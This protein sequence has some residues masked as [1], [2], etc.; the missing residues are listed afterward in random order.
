MNSNIGRILIADDDEAVRIYMQSFLK[1]DRYRLFFARDGDEAIATAEKERPD[2]IL[3]DVDMPGASGVQVC[4][5]IKSNP[6]LRMIPVVLVTSMS[7]L[8]SRVE[9]L[10]AGADDFFSK[11]FEPT[12]LL[13]RIRSLLT[14]KHYTDQLEHAEKVIASLALCV[15][16]KDT[17]TGGHCE[18]LSQYAVNLGRQMGLADRELRALRLG[19]ILHDLGKIAVPDAV[20]LKP[21]P[22]T[23]EEWKIMRNHP[24]RGI[25]LCLPLQSLE[26]V[27]PAIKHH[28]ERWNGSGYPDHLKGEDIPFTARIMAV[29]DVYDALR[30]RRSYKPALSKEDSL[31]ILHKEVEYGFWDP[32]IVEFFL[33]SIKD[34][35]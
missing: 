13:T 22:L 29:I 21:G 24:V 16:A 30:T 11:P 26:T 14:L 15:E 10:A 25:E 23:P 8:A 6:Q 18:R 5:Q 2:L 31:R 9:G 3:L 27:I 34:I 33:Q 20:L 1:G 35:P 19:G 32:R 12:E 28:H 17:Y 7:D 4:K